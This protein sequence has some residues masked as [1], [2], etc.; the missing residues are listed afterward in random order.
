MRTRCPQHL[1]YIHRIVDRDRPGRTN[2]SDNI[3]H[4]E[5]GITTR[6]TELKAQRSETEVNNNGCSFMKKA[7]LDRSFGSRNFD[8]ILLSASKVFRIRRSCMFAAT[9][10]VHRARRGTALCSWRPSRQQQIRPA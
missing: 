7:A 8:E 6:S 9:T 1:E 2:L 3:D 5:L 10:S 4:P